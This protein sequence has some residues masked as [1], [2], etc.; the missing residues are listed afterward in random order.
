MFTRN[1]ASCRPAALVVALLFAT[2][3]MAGAATQ[4]DDPRSRAVDALFAQFDRPGSPGAAVGIYHAGR[5]VYTHAYGHAELEHAVPMTSQTIFNAASVSKQFTAF[6][7]ALLAREGKVNLDADIRTYLPYVPDFGHAITVRHLLHHTSGLRTS[8]LLFELGGQDL[9]GVLHSQQVVNMVARQRALNFEPGAEFLYCNT[10]YSL[11]AEIVAAV[12]GQSFRQFTTQRIFQPL[13]MT[14]SFFYDDVTEIVPGRA[15]SYERSEDGS[16]WLRSVENYD[17]IGAT[18]LMTSVEDMLKWAANFTRP[19]VGDRALIEQMAEGGKLNDGESINYGFGL[20]R[21]RF[22]GHEAWTHTGSSAGYA[23]MFAYFPGRDF[24]VVVLANTASD[25][26]EPAEAIA[27]LYLNGA[28]EPR[29]PP[30]AIEPEAA[31]VSAA[32]GRYMSEFGPMV[33]LVR[34]GNTLLWQQVGSEPERLTFRADGAFGLGNDASAYYRFMRGAAGQVEGFERIT[35]GSGH[36]QSRHRRVI[37]AKPSA[38]ELADLAGSYFSPELDI[39]YTFTLEAGRLAARSI[40]SVEPI[41]F[42]PGIADRFDS[43]H[44]T[45]STIVFVRDARG[46]VNGL[47]VHADGIRDVLLRRVP[48]QP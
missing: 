34:E 6:A 48:A 43:P 25:Q 13:R 16:R 44:W 3:S 23:A 12:S 24:A 17:I 41:V 31:V 26:V 20:R 22:A 4:Q 27:D 35:A 19:V 33:T 28:H 2:G 15:Q 5:A 10:G 11:L 8:E 7:I 14:H 36:T 18:G 40:W 1:H 39:T 30:D 38:A 45:M 37:P 46:R 21:Q 42:T 32:A 29:P 9:R 47:R